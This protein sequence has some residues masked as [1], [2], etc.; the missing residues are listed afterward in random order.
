MVEF[1]NIVC[2][3][4]GKDLAYQ[5]VSST[6]EDHILK[7]K[8]SHALLLLSSHAIKQQSDNNA[9]NIFPSCIAT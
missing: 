5:V 4:T 6:E 9:K 7:K 3:C 2:E 1:K 8:E